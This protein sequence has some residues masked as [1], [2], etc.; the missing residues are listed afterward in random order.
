MALYF[1]EQDLLVLVKFPIQKRWRNANVRRPFCFS[2]DQA[3]F[4]RSG[5]NVQ[6]AQDSEPIRL[7]ESS[8]SLSV[9]ILTTS[10]SHWV[11]M[12]LTITITITITS[13][14]LV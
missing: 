6:I 1:L 10:D 12:L 2:L 4:T 11:L 14:M 5:V 8:R 9:Y 7:L 3:L 13:T